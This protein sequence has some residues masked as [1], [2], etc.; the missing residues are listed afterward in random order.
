MFT[1][2]FSLKLKSENVDKILLKKG[3]LLEECEIFYS[4][5]T[6]WL[7]FLFMMLSIT[8]P[9]LILGFE[10]LFFTFGVYILSYFIMAYIVMVYLDNTPVLVKNELIIINPYFPFRYFKSYQIEEIQKVKIDKSS[11]FFL[12]WL[13]LFFRINYVEIYANE[14]NRRFYCSSL[15]LDS[16]DENWTEKTMDDFQ[17]SLLVRGVML[18]FELD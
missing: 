12:S 17:Y 10:H 1:T 4:P 15:D 11:S 14:S 18:E 8:F 16:Y 3:Y 6:S 13:F 5:I 2:G 9:L 7:V